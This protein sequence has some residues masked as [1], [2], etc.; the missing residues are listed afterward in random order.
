MA[1]LSTRSVEPRSFGAE[2]LRERLAQHDSRV[3]DR[4]VGVNLEI[5][6]NLDVEVEPAVLAELGQHV[7]E[8]RQSRFRRGGPGT[9]ESEE[10]GDVG[11]VCRSSPRGA[12]HWRGSVPSVKPCP[13]PGTPRSV[14]Q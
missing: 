12:G 9:V 10:H 3:L 14:C 5:A 11:L 8:E 6:A 4:V 2:R 1:L 13:F 7:V